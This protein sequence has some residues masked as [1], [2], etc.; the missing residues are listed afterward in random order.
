M[1]NLLSELKQVIVEFEFTHRWAEI[2]KWWTV[3][4]LLNKSTAKMNDIPEIAD[5]MELDENELWNAILFYKL[6][7]D[8]NMLP[9]GKNISWYKIREK[10]L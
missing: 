7:P 1:N 6:Y 3:G 4:E 2:E 9:E 10:Y 5:Y 8:L